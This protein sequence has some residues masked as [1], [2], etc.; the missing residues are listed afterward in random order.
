MNT[1]GRPTTPRR[2][3]VDLWGARM[4]RGVKWS[5]NG[6]PVNPYISGHEP[7]SIMAWDRALTLHRQMRNKGDADY[8]IA[9]H[10]HFYIDDRKFDGPRSG[11]WAKPERLVEVARHFDGVMGIDFSTYADFPE[12]IKRWQIYRMRTLERFVASNGVEVIQNFRWGGPETWDY[13]LDVLHRNA[14]L[15]LGTVASGLRYL[16]NRPAFARGLLHGVRSLEPSV[17]YVVGSSNYPVF[18]EVRALGTRVVTFDG[19]TAAA[20]KAGGANV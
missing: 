5:E 20:H 1:T 6:N 3:I 18:D 4:T 19:P 15:S 2:G 8:R 17:I 7:H 12:P 10:I 13:F 14:P 9:A 16:E 11:I